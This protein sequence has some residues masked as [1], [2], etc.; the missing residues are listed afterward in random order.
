MSDRQSSGKSRECRSEGARRVTLDHQHV[1]SK[2]ERSQQGG[3]DGLH[4]A[5]RVLFAGTTE[6]IDLQAHEPK[7]VRI[8]VRVL[9]GQNELRREAALNKSGGNWGQL[10]RF[11]PGANDQSDIR[12]TQ[13]SP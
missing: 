12:V 4:V 6:T 10:D 1:E 9:A 2:A 7:R 3:S 8:E 13:P 5:M 11:R